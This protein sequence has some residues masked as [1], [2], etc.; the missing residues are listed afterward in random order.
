MLWENT[1]LGRFSENHFFLLKEQHRMHIS[2]SPVCAF[3]ANA[4]WFCNFWLCF[5]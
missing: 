2:G 5:R 3:L 4:I 1:M